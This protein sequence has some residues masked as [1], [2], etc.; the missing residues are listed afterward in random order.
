MASLVLGINDLR[1]V[2]NKYSKYQM[3]W[4][5]IGLQLE[6]EKHV[7]DTIKS[8]YQN[9][10]GD[11]FREMLAHWLQND[12]SATTFRLR[13]AIEDIECSTNSLTLS[14]NKWYKDLGHH[15]AEIILLSILGVILFMYYQDSNSP[16]KSAEEILKNEYRAHKVIKFNLPISGNSD[17]EYLGVVMKDTDGRE[18]GHSEL[19]QNY[20]GKTGCLVVIRLPGSGKTTLLRHLAKKWANGR[21]LKSCQILFLILLDSLEGEVNA[22]GDLLS[23][24]GFGDL[25]NLKD[26]SEKIYATNGAGA[27]FLIDAY[28]ELKWNRCKFIDAIMEDNEI[29]S[30]LYSREVNMI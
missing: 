13:K 3:N 28:G 12:K 17:L 21:A 7:L 15:W 25:M 10:I 9:K 14:L 1:K 4:Y 24:S 8:D 23:K 5:D 11:C 30:L 20:S 26:I 29:H 2:L 19:V 22:L 6:I 27:C 18:F 16:I